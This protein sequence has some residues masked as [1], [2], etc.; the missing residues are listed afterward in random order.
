MQKTF[1]EFIRKCST[2]IAGI[3]SEGD[4]F[5]FTS[6]DE[7][8]FILEKQTKNELIFF[9]DKKT[10]QLTQKI[11]SIDTTVVISCSIQNIGC[12]VS[13]VI[14]KLEPLNLV[15]DVPHE[16]FKHI[17]ANGGTSENFYPPEAFRT[18]EYSRVSAYYPADGKLQI[19]SECNGRSSNL[20]LP[21]LIF[22]IDF[23]DETEGF[24]CGMEWSGLWYITSENIGTERCTIKAGVKVND[25]V[26]SPGE[27]LRL[28]KVHIGFFKGRADE[29]TNHIRKYL[30]NHICPK[31]QDKPV[32]PPVTY[33]HWAHI[34][35]DYN[36]DFLKKQALRA[37]QVG[38]EI[39][40]LDAAWFTGGFPSGVGNWE[41]VDKDKFPN[42]I[43]ELRDY[44]ED[45]G[46]G[47]GLWFEV[48]RVATGTKLYDEHPDW[49][50]KNHLNL[51]KKDVQ[52]YII[53]IISD[54]IE[55]LNLVWIRWDYNIDPIE[56]WMAADPSLK[57]QFAYMEGLYRVLDG[58]I[59]KYPRL[60]IEGCA[61]GGRRIDIGTIRRSHTFWISDHSCNPDVCRYMQA[62][63]NR[64]LPGHLLNSSIAN[65]IGKG[66]MDLNETSVISRMLGKLAFD[67]DI[68]SWSSDFTGIAAFWSN[69]FKKIRHLLS[70]DFF[71]LLPIP[72][73]MED[74]DALQ[75]ID[76]KHT[77]GVLFVFCGDRAGK[78]NIS[79][80]GLK[81]KTEYSIKRIRINGD[82]IMHLI[83]NDLMT[84]GIKCD[85]S[86]HEAGLWIIKN[87]DEQM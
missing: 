9:N 23:G 41:I 36:C 67:G 50:I 3:L 60:M 20:H 1:N 66:S 78:K 48:E 57:I 53:R 61:S 51:A 82:Q 70:Q 24:F 31:Y 16:K 49:H 72:T 69:E 39:F 34:W 42:G 8:E 22:L 73:T 35:G 59:A 74:W 30:N 46:M 47:F 80:K 28:P 58:L 29:A 17:Y 79:L 25:L 81:R 18:F 32:I 84:K 10:M 40:V 54:Y 21:I 63:S 76:H 62:R 12:D 7:N 71:Q 87:S 14:N 19:E 77:E 26:L 83:G 55:K 45:L 15:F 44:V 75:F 86:A 52:D 2:G 64:F 68:A 38:V 13:L 6:S 37:A 85:L 5:L 43:E 4:G 65:P 27:I 11:E 56:F 33:D